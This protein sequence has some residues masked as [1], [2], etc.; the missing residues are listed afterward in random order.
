FCR[1]TG[2]FCLGAALFFY[3]GLLGL[4]L[5]E[6][7]DL[8]L[9]T[10]PLFFLLFYFCLSLKSGFTG[11]PFNGGQPCFLCFPRTA[12]CISFC[13]LAGAVFLPRA[14]VDPCLFRIVRKYPEDRPGDLVE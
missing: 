8:G 10:S 5:T 9:L 11:Q 4:L 14:G 1:L 13:R 2:P 6:T 7:F 12:L 3:L